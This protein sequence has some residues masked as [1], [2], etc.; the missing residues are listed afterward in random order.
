[1][2]PE[3]NRDFVGYLLIGLMA[4]A[5]ALVAASVL[6]A[7]VSTSVAG[8]RVSAREVFRP[9][10]VAIVLALI[11]AW[12]SERH[13]RLLRDLMIAVERHAAAIAVALAIVVFASATRMSLFEARAS[14]QWGYVSQAELWA[15]G[16][17]VTPM[18]LAATAPWPNATWT[19]SPLGYRPGLTPA[20]I[21]PTYPPG[22]PL[23]MAAFIKVFGSFGAFIVVPLLG[24]VAVVVTFVLGRRLGGARCGLFG[25]ML[26][27]SSPIFLNQLREP[28]SD[29]PVTAWWLLATVLVV[30]STSLAALTA[31]VAASAAI[32]TR[33]N[34]AP[35]AAVI[36]VFVLCCAGS[37]L[38]ARLRNAACFAV[39]ALPGCVG[40]AL[41]N[42]RL[43]GSAFESGYGSTEELFKLEYL[44]T[45][46][47][48]YPRWLI[49]TE[50]PLILLALAA[51]WLMR[52]SL[53]WMFL[54][55]IAVVGASYA[56]YLPFDN[57]TYLRFLLPAIALMLVLSGAVI[58]RLAERVPS[59]GARWSIAAVCLALM[60]WRWDNAGMQPPRPNDRRF[61]VVGEFVRD[62]LP[63][64]AIVL[65]MQHSG[66][67]RYY[68]GRVTLRWDLLD[69]EWLERSLVFL[70]EQGY[71]PFLLLEEWE[72]PLFKERFAG[73]TPLAALDWQPA[74]TYSGEVQTDVFDPADRGAAGGPSASKVIAAAIE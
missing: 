19:F 71:Y 49:E 14:D 34:L 38:R 9:T 5:L 16:D 24:A 1:M 36:G 4:A 65:S 69:A 22:L 62:E 53:S 51:P 17:L 72:Q 47:T 37:S 64:N 27:S 3:R 46:L 11:A 35:L 73:H 21:V 68:S 18:P 66:S 12:R 45:N 59:R 40:L 61:A 26:V 56:F 2:P 30:A 67:I 60:A 48:T 15:R 6:G 63:A 28:M 52:S 42:Q 70:R 33:P 20:T 8:I 13:A 44:G 39:G 31:G 57:W 55:L 41:I 32:M 50:T 74:A 29:V 10:V 43:Y 25:A 23:V 54:A 58:L 7:G